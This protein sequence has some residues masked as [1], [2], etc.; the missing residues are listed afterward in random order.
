LQHHFLW[1]TVCASFLV[2]HRFSIKQQLFAEVSFAV[3]APLRG[4]CV[5]IAAGGPPGNAA[6]SS[7]E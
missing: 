7:L 2:F 1:R 5:E 4:L 6:S 3:F